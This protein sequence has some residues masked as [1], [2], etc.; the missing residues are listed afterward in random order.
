MELKL[1]EFK[2]ETYNGLLRLQ[3]PGCRT[4]VL[5][6]DRETKDTLGSKFFKTMWP[7]RKNKT[8]NFAYMFIEKGQS[9]FMDILQKAMY[10]SDRTQN[11]NPKNCV[12]TVLAL[13]AYRRLVHIHKINKIIHLNLKIQML[14][15]NILKIYV[16]ILGLKCHHCFFIDIFACTMQNI[17]KANEKI[18][19]VSN[20][21]HNVSQFS[22]KIHEKNIFVVAGGS[23][24]GFDED[25][26]D[27]EFNNDP[28]MNLRQRLVNNTKDKPIRQVI[29]RKKMKNILMNFQFHKKKLYLFYRMNF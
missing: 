3:M 11:I 21:F 9:W 26:D 14:A 7:Y 24:L 17:Q 15:G 25:S 8:L 29:S 18:L 13:N 4:L 23:F 2:A 16:K 27:E 19:E 1:I 5:I 10:D 6:L 22:I 20:H 28:E 12:G